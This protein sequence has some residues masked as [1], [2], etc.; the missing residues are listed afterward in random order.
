LSVDNFLKKSSIISMSKE[1]L[2][3]ISQACMLLADAEGLGA[4]KASVKERIS[5]K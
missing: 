5:L 2:N 1:G 4:H 3:E